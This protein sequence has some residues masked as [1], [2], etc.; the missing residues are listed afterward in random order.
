MPA[1]L[2]IFGA[3]RLAQ[4][5]ARLWQDHAVF[6][7][8]QIHCRQLSSS[9]QAQAFIGAQTAKCIEHPDLLQPSKIWLVATPDSAFINVEKHLEPLIRPGDI[10]FHC[11]GALA[12]DQFGSLQHLG[13]LVA[14]IHPL[15]SFATP[16]HS[17]QQFSGSYCAYEGDRQALDI[18][19]PAFEKIGAQCFEIKGDK[20]LYHAGSVIAC[21]YLVPLLNASYQAFAAAG[22]QQPLAEKL[23]QPLLEGT[24]NNIRTQGPAAAL[25][26]PI[27]RGD[28]AFVLQQLTAL[29]ESNPQLGDFYKDMAKHTTQLALTRDNSD[30]I[31]LS[32]K[33]LAQTLEDH[34]QIGNEL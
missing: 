1:S 22:I 21:N 32:L 11:S 29:K 14:S 5:L 19:I 10:V 12:S 28:S 25:T 3:G 4:T 20:W 15:H 2:S 27:A 31:T 23:L 16:A 13:A 18:L 17:I 26:G 33:D 24:L 9:S 30:A 8:H 34:Q 7:I 6:D